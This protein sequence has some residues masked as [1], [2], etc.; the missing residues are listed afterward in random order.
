M[1]KFYTISAFARLIGVSPSTLREYDKSG[2][3][4]PHHRS[5]HGYRYY[6]EEQYQAFVRNKTRP[7]VQQ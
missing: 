6:S 4:V 1:C 5:P 2:T 7:K 3:L